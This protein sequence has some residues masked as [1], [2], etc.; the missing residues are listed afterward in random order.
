MIFFFYLFINISA[1]IELQVILTNR[2]IMDSI[3]S[4]GSIVG[5]A[6]KIENMLGAGACGEVYSVTAV[7]KLSKL[8]PYACV[9]KV[10]LLLKGRTKKEQKEHTLNVANTLHYEYMLYQGMLTNFEHCAQFPCAYGAYGEWNGVRYLVMERMDGDLMD[11]ARASPAPSVAEVAD[12]GRQVLE[13]M[14]ALHK[15]FYVFVDVKPDNFMYKVQKNGQKKIFFIDF[16]LAQAF[17]DMRTQAHRV[18]ADGPLVGTPTYVSRAVHNGSI[19]ARRDDV[20]AVC[21]V[22]LSMLG[23]G[24]LPWSSAKSEADCCAQ[25]NACDVVA[26]STERGAPE[27]GQI[28]EATRKL[29][30]AEKPKYLEY[31]ALLT[32]MAKGKA[33]PAPGGKKKA[34]TNEGAK[35]KTTRAAASK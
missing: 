6:W 9:M 20:E 7:G 12:Y 34:A 10:T 35:T 14:E 25:K 16:G 24:T 8:V 33:A 13:G 3:L 23:G 32:K 22:L 2:D 19:C 11:L 18:E 21:W 26:L 30:F 5:G 4:K 29:A 28:V 15:R 17:M 1:S 31:I 27:L